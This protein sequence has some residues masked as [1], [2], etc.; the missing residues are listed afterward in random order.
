MFEEADEDGRAGP[1]S[2]DVAELLVA[3]PDH[4]DVALPR[5]ISELLGLV[6]EKM[7][8][9]AV[10]VRAFRPN[11][12]NAAVTQQPDPL[13]AAWAEHVLGEM[14]PNGD[15]A[16]TCLHAPVV[17]VDGSIYGT[18][19]AFSRDQWTRQG[20]LQI[21]RSTAKL[22]A[23][24]IWQEVWAGDSA[25]REGRDPTSPMRREPATSN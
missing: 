5:A 13:E 24:K 6:R 2:V 23:Q 12:P 14:Q 25:A 20:D 8:L 1:D 15:P 19:C 3:T 18:L 4:G 21:L 7:K 9:N 22:I 16:A 10:F 11:Q 17:M